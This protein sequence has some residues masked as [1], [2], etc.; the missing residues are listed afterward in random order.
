MQRQQK[1]LPHFSFL[2]MACLFIGLATRAE[3]QYPDWINYNATE[4][5]RAVAVEGNYIWI[6][7]DNDLA[8]FDK[9]TGQMTLYPIGS[10][11]N[12]IA[13][14]NNGVKWVGTDGGLIRFDDNNWTVYDSNN[15]GLPGYYVSSIAI[16]ANGVKWIGTTNYSSSDGGGL[17]SFDDHNW[18]VFNKSNSGLPTNWVTAIAIDNNGVKWIG[19]F[20]EGLARFD[21]KSWTVYNK[22]N[23]DLPHNRVN[24][25][26]IDDDDVKWIGTGYSD[27][28]LARFDD[29]NWTI[30]NPSNPIFTIAIDNSGVKWIGTYGLVRFD[31]SNWTVYKVDNSGLPQNYIESLAIDSDNVVWIGAPNPHEGGITRFDGRNWA[32]YSANVPA[33]QILSI[34]IDSD[35]VK[36]LGI[37]TNGYSNSKDRLVSFSDG[38]TWTSHYEGSGPPYY[39]SAAIVIDRKGVKWIGGGGLCRFDGNHWTVYN[40]RNSGLPDYNVTAIAIDDKDVKWIGTYGFG[41]RGGGLSR[42]DD[43]TWTVY[44]TGNSDLIQALA[45]DNSGDIWVGRRGSGLARFDGEGWTVYNTANSALPNNT[46]HVITIDRHGVKWIGTSGG[47][48]RFDDHNWT[49]YNV[50]TPDKNTVTA[51]AIDTNDVKWI[52]TGY[53]AFNGYFRYGHLLRF[54]DRNWVVYDQSNSRMPVSGVSAIT[55]DRNGAKWIGTYWDG[56]VVYLGDGVNSAEIT[57]PQLLKQNYPNPIKTATTIA[58]SQSAYA[59]VSVVVYNVNGQR[60]RQLL[61]SR[62]PSGEHTLSWDGLN[63]KGEMAA[64]GVYFYQLRIGDYEETKKMVLVRSNDE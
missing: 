36:W 42:F 10:R 11:V 52:G 54:D 26:A 39:I 60:V 49:V 63:D 28:G 24:A 35:N 9:I 3:A 32:G 33:N 8:R 5:G 56:L 53:S 16:D 22:S 48:A 57:R 37:G 59:D 25:I 23:S 31:G 43:S 61:H 15:S 47:L 27:G 12:A 45:I 50:G 14:D 21:G 38:S 19:T 58:W 20:W 18:T 13:I 7:R 30:Y 64:N 17:A 29:S 62:I 6:G 51:I 4:E 40:T 55:I 34:A 41:E 1:R 2:F 44:N 46:I